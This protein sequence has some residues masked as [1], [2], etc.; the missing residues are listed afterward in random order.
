M[1]F[2]KKEYD[3]QYVKTHYQE[4]KARFKPD[5][6]LKIDDYCKYNGLSFNEFISLAAKYII[7]EKVDLNGYK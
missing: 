3:K 4:K 7:D 5:L 2:N 6:W 1:A